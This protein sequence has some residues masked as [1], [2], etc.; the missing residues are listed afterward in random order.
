[1]PKRNELKNL[2][3]RLE[4]E[5]Q[6]M[7]LEIKSFLEKESLGHLPDHKLE[8]LNEVVREIADHANLIKQIKSSLF[9]EE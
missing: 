7:V 2:L 6:K 8:R 5:N 3:H 9:H 1:M 4:E